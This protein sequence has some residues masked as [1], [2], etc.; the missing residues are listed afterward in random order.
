MIAEDEL[1]CF[2]FDEF[3]NGTVSDRQV[4]QN[5]QSL[6]NDVFTVT[7]ILQVCDAVEWNM[8][9]RCGQVKTGHGL[10]FFERIHSGPSSPPS[11]PTLQT[12]GGKLLKSSVPDLRYKFC[13]TVQRNSEAKV[14]TSHNDHPVMRRFIINMVSS[15]ELLT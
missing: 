11:D 2:E 1:Y 14:P 12:I 9:V 8:R 3:S 10:T 5:L 15:Y 4:I 6:T 7:P 13:E